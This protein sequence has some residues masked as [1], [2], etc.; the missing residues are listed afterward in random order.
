MTTLAP[1]KHASLRMA[2]RGIN[3]ND[4]E[5]IAAAGTP[6]ADG[7]LFRN[8]DY[9]EVERSIKDFLQRIRRLV[10][11]RLIVAD[12]RIVTVYHATECHQRHLLRAASDA[13]LCD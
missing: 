9:Q 2:Q 13:D 12:G 6:V 5:L 8:K 3:P 7:Y 11:K 4:A 10:G 1:T